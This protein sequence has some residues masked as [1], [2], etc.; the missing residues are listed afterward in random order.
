MKE[1]EGYTHEIKTSVEVIL[2]FNDLVE[3][4]L[5]M[6]KI[7]HSFMKEMKFLC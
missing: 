3:Q 7:Q 4:K 1:C 5:F 6:T 2:V